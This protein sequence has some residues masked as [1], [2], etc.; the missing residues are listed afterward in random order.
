M[1][2]SSSLGR[3]GRT[4]LGFFGGIAVGPPVFGVLLRQ[5]G[6][7]SAAWTLLVFALCLGAILCRNLYRA[8][9]GEEARPHA[10]TA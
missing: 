7:F 4:S 2:S 5:P 3:S 9:R 1:I 6:G 8:R 10:G